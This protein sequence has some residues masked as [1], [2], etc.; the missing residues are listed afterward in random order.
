MNL[1]GLLF[2]IAATASGFALGSFLAGELGGLVGIAAGAAWGFRLAADCA[3]LLEED[4]RRTRI[5]REGRFAVLSE[6]SHSHPSHPRHDSLRRRQRSPRAMGSNLATGKE[7]GLKEIHLALRRINSHIW[8]EL[9]GGALAGCHALLYTVRLEEGGEA[10]DWREVNRR[11][12]SALRGFE[13][14]ATDKERYESLMQALDR[15]GQKLHIVK[16][17]AAL[18]GDSIR[19]ERKELE[20]NEAELWR[21]SRL[22]RSWSCRLGGE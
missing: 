1:L 5:L 12:V 6:S 10:L 15:I 16:V 22:I 8:R 4:R 13:T 14:A 21:L 20:Q 17:V 2:V 7:P 11:V 18:K 9:R 19:E 3:R